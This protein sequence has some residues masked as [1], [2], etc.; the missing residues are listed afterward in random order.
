MVLLWL[1][2]LFDALSRWHVFAY[3]PVAN[4]KSVAFLGRLVKSPMISPLHPA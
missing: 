3:H 2:V 1:S 4:V